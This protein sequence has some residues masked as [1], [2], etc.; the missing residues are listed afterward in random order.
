MPIYEYS[1]D[2]CG[3]VLERIQ[4]FIDSREKYHYAAWV[5]I[6]SLAVLYAFEIDAL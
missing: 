4:K 3:N 6:V 2:K 5:I 1:C